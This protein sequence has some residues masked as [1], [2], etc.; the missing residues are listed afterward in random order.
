M[1]LASFLRTGSSRLVAPSSHLWL[2]SCVTSKNESRSMLSK[3]KNSTN[4]SAPVLFLELGLT[5]RGIDDIGDVTSITL[6]PDR[7]STIRVGENVVRIEWDGHYRSEADEL[8]HATWET[9]SEVTTLALP[10]EGRIVS[11]D[12]DPPYYLEE[13]VPLLRLA[14]CQEALQANLPHLVTL[15]EYLHSVAKG[16]PGKFAEDQGHVS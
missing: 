7:E 4:Q 10:I 9:Y 11:A 15:Q 1:S 13:N 2:R 12:I 5:Q 6:I 3:E 16:A 8:Y 14:T